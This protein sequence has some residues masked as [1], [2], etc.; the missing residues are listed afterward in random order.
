MTL[1]GLDDF[2]VHMQQLIATGSGEEPLI[3]SDDEN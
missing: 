3:P 2:L 1:R